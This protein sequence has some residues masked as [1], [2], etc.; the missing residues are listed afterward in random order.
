MRKPKFKVGQV[1][2]VAEDYYNQSKSS[3]GK[4]QSIEITQKVKMINKKEVTSTVI[5]YIV[6]IDSGGRV[7]RYTENRIADSKNSFYV[8]QRK[9]EK[10]AAQRA[11]TRAQNTLAK[12]QKKLEELEKQLKISKR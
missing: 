2:H 1:V 12:N 8:K 7:L 5:S 6:K 4:I 11:L 3:L 10:S 9:K